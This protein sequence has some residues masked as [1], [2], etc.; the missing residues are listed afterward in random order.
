MGL[1]RCFVQFGEFVQL[2][3][4]RP[5]KPKQTTQTCALSSTASETRSINLER[6]GHRSSRSPRP[7]GP[8]HR[9]DR[10][11]RLKKPR[12]SQTQFFIA[13]FL[14]KHTSTDQVTTSLRSS[15]A[16]FAS[17]L[18]AWGFGAAPANPRDPKSDSLP[19]DAGKTSLPLVSA[20]RGG[21]APSLASLVANGCFLTLCVIRI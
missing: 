2:D 9:V 1:V 20:L 18:A 5:M 7:D 16:S 12:P 17:L 3:V 19:H 14:P 4:G 11:R 13:L 15:I 8:W 21:S 10:P 6:Q